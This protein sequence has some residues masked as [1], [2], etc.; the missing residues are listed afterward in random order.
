M[1]K[2]SAENERIKRKYFVYGA[3]CESVNTWLASDRRYFGATPLAPAA[4]NQLPELWPL[5][6]PPME[7][8]WRSLCLV[9]GFCCSLST[10]A[11]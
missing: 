3:R 8:R 6:R 2:H 4:T 7:G 5:H 9:P 1:T 11:R 10:F